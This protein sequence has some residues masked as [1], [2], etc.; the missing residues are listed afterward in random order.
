MLQFDLQK[1]GLR[2]L[3]SALQNHKEE[4][5]QTTWEVINP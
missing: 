3:N 2:N 4:T 5:N 1:D